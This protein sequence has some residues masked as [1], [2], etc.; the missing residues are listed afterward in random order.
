MED[1]RHQPE[2][3]EVTMESSGGALHNPSHTH[4]PLSYSAHIRTFDFHLAAF[5]QTN[6]Y[7]KEVELLNNFV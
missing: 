1:V 3:I 5:S 6:S 2:L 7:I 4:S